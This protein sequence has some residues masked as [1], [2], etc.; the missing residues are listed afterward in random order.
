VFALPL[1]FLFLCSSFAVYFSSF[2][3]FLFFF[4]FFFFVFFFLPCPLSSFGSPLHFPFFSLS[5]L[6]F[7]FVFGSWS[8]FLLFLFFRWESGGGLHWWVSKTFLVAHIICFCLDFWSRKKS[9]LPSDPHCLLGYILFGLYFL[10]R[11]AVVVGIAPFSFRFLFFGW[12]SLPFL[13]LSFSVPIYLSFWYIQSLTNTS[14]TIFR[15]FFGLSARSSTYCV[16]LE[17]PTR[18]FC[19][20][21]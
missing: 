8:F 3:F 19:L 14:R 7:F 1:F 10:G 2:V 16:L 12:F 5:L 17:F 21:N 4:L 13:L 11:T 6:Y 9:L 20:F 18:I 15:V